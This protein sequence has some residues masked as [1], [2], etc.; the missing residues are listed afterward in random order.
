MKELIVGMIKK[1]YTVGHE[2]VNDLGFT[3]QRVVWHKLNGKKQFIRLSQEK[4]I[5]TLLEVEI[6]KGLGDDTLLDKR[7]H[8][9]YRSLLGSINWIQSRTQFPYCYTFSRL[10][11]AS[12]SPKVTMQ[13]N[14]STTS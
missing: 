1:E 6:P 8:T 7:L 4:S 14:Q 3:G 11:S 9:E 5:E 13:T 10:A 12:A 2:D